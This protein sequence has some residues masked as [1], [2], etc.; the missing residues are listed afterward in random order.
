MAPKTKGE[1]VEALSEITAI[2]AESLRTMTV[3]KLRLVYSNVKARPV[4]ILPVNWRRFKKAELRQVYEETVMPFY[5]S[6]PRSSNHAMW[7]RVAAA[8]LWR[9]RSTPQ[10]LVWKLRRSSRPGS[11]NVQQMQD[12]YGGE[13][14]SHDRS[15]VL[16]V[17]GVPGLH[18]DLQQDL[19]SVT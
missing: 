16:G 4:Q 18:R 7:T 17:L 12:S 5:Q 13:A 14:Q 3:E 1:Y 19:E 11:P 9:S 2:N 10:T 6:T 15:D 8:L